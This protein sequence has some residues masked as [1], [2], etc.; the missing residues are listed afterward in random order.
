MER[1]AFRAGRVLLPICDR[2]GTDTFDRE[3]YDRGG[4]EAGNAFPPKTTRLAVL[5]GR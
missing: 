5:A 1:E 2:P 3:R 4:E